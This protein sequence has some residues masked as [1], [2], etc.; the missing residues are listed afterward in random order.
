MAGRVRKWLA[1]DRRTK[2]LLLEAYW[3]LG[4]A[5]IVKAMPFSKVAPSL[6]VAMEE[7]AYVSSPGHEETARMISRTL[8][9]MS[10]YTLWESKC[11]VMAIA[12]MKMMEKRGIEST[13]YLGTKKDD[14]GKMSAHAWLRAGA[15]YA[16]G[17]EIMNQY[18]V[19]AMFA[20]D[21]TVFKGE[22]MG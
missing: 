2:L 15:F 4:W 14:S 11:M 10:R 16:T 20:N 6:G 8:R 21:A 9:I 7:T 13:L 12:G 3:Y 18:T 22:R 19:V 1:S 17:A 5:R